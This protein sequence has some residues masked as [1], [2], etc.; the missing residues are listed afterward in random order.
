MNLPT[1][2][3]PGKTHLRTIFISG[4]HL[5]TR[6]CQAEKLASFLKLHT[7]ERLYLVGDTIDGWRMKASG[8]Y[9]PQ[10]HINVVHH[11]SMRR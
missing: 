6:G 7:C 1:V 11:G 8:V 2:G 4:V 9:W 3:E 10:S 5:G